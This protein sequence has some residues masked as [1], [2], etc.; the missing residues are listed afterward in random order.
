[1]A[2][3]EGKVAFITG[4]SSGIGLGVACAFADAGMKVVIT[5]RTEEHIDDALSRLGPSL[6]RVHAIN[7]D[8]MDRPGLEAAAREAVEVFGKVNVLVNNAGINNLV[9]LTKTSYDEWDW[10]I[11]VNLTGVFNGVPRRSASHSSAR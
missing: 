9:S 1:M 8:V 2:H 5:Y 7:V 11:G 10:V 6:D 4:G 3:V